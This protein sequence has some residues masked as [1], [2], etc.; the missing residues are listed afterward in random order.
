MNVVSGERWRGVS[1]ECVRSS[2]ATSTSRR[3]GR[4]RGGGPGP[5]AA[6]RGRAARPRPISLEGAR[7]RFG[8]D[9]W[10]A[11]EQEL[12]APLQLAGDQRRHQ[13]E[14]LP[15]RAWHGYDLMPT[16]PAH[17]RAARTRVPSPRLPPTRSASQAVEAV[18]PGLGW[19]CHRVPP[20]QAVRRAARRRRHQLRPRRCCG[21]CVGRLR[22]RGP[23]HRVPSRVDPRDDRSH[24]ADLHR[25]HRGDRT[26]QAPSTPPPG[27]TDTQRLMAA[28]G[29]A[30]PRPTMSAGSDADVSPLAPPRRRRTA[31]WPGSR[32]RRGRGRC[33]R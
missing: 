29:R 2:S 12:A 16:R 1:D 17:A 6:A 25:A 22:E 11:D 5:V 24:R 9:I 4:P 10:K 28:A 14:A 27:A 19:Q 13:N 31:R 30:I 23:R 3:V 26:G 15:R 20:P 7:E 18:S 8:A 32:W 33:G 21:A